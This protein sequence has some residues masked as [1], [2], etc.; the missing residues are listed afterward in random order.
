MC[1][2]KDSLL[3]T[4]AP[5]GQRGPVLRVYGAD[6]SA[7]EWKKRLC[8][9]LMERKEKCHDTSNRLGGGHPRRG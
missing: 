3:Y 7:E 9:W 5:A 8:G 1:D 6:I 2:Q 4:V